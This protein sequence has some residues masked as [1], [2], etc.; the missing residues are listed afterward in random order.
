M[1]TIL[2]PHPAS[3]EPAVRRTAGGITPRQAAS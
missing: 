2:L 3:R 1:K